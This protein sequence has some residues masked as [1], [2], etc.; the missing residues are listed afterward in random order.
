MRQSWDPRFKSL[1]KASRMCVTALC[2]SICL[3]SVASQTFNGMAR[4]Y[5]FECGRGHQWPATAKNVVQG[6][7]WC[8]HCS[9]P[10]P[11]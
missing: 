2:I 3:Q 5:L 4:K 1:N 11:H 10:G 9:K 7:S 8:P 6:G